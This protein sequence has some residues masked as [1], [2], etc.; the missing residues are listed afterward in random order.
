MTF[1]NTNIH[2]L[3]KMYIDSVTSAQETQDIQHFN[4]VTCILNL[5]Y[6]AARVTEH[7]LKQKDE[8]KCYTFTFV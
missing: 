5:G 2:T 7:I 1:T 3:V 4:T 6:M 8:N